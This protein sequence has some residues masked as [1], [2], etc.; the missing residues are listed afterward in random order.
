MQKSFFHETPKGD[1]RERKDCKKEFLEG[2]GEGLRTR[3]TMSEF[4]WFSPQLIKLDFQRKI[5]WAFR[6]KKLTRGPFTRDLTCLKIPT[7]N[8]KP[9]IILST[10]T[11]NHSHFLLPLPKQGQAIV[12]LAKTV[13]NVEVFG[14]CSKNKHEA[15]A[16]TGQIDHLLERGSDYMNEVRK[17]VAP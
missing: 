15:L 10:H 2:S 5:P 3:I 8:H 1:T 17:W 11:P 4:W 6:G 7:I 16:A 12:Q 9:S 14:V 13:E